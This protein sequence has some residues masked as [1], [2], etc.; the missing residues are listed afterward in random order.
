ME[1]KKR[2]VKEIQALL[3][4]FEEEEIH[5]NYESVTQNDRQA[6]EAKCRTHAEIDS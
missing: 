6:G 4:A 1:Q 5:Q 2:T 3:G